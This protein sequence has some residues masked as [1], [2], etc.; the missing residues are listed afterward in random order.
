MGERDQRHPHTG[1]PPDLGR[2]HAAGVDDDL[3]LDVAPV[4]AHAA[5][6]AV[7]DV[8]PGH[9][10][11]GEDPAAAAAGAVGE[12]VGQ[13]RGVEVAVGR[14][15]GGA[16]HSLGRHQREQ[17][18]GLLGRDQLQRQPEGLRPAGLAAQL[19]QSLLAGGKADAAALDPARVELGLVLEPPVEVDR[20]HHHL[21][22]RDRAAQLP[23]QAGRVEGRPRG[24]LGA[25]EQDDVVPAELGQV[26]RQRG[27]ADAAADDHAAGRRRQLSPRRHPRPPARSRTPGR[28][29]SRASARSARRRIRGSRS[30]CRRGRSGEPPTSPRGSRT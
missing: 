21:G 16:Q 29:R 4:G 27:A 2:E 20:V 14:Q 3:G 5:H 6:P 12:R 18:P 13:L 26:V 30:R 17:L 10:G 11:R 9:P 7:A 28:M 8:D 25:L 15:P 22:Q 1:H 24:E 23:D 19:L